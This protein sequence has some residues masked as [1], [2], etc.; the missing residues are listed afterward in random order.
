VEG[1]EE[2]RETK[3]RS[4]PL[5]QP[6]SLARIVKDALGCVLKEYD[7]VTLERGGIGWLYITGTNF[8]DLPKKNRL[9]TNFLTTGNGAS[10]R[11]RG[12]GGGGGGAGSV[13][14]VGGGVRAAGCGRGRGGGRGLITSFWK[15]AVPASAH[16]GPDAGKEK[17]LQDEELFGRVSAEGV[18]REWGEEVEVEH[19]QAAHVE[20]TSSDRVGIGV[21]G[22][23]GGGE[24]EGGED[25]GGEGGR[26]GWGKED[27]ERGGRRER[28]R[29]GEA[30]GW[31]GGERGAGEG[32]GQGGMTVRD[33]VCDE[34]C[35]LDM[36]AGANCTSH[37]SMPNAGG[38]GG[39]GGGEGGA[40]GLIGAAEHASSC[41][42]ADLE[43]Q[44]QAGE[45]DVEAAF[46]GATQC[47]P[48]NSGPRGFD[49]G[50]E[51][52]VGARS[53]SGGWRRGTRVPHERLSQQQVEQQHF[54]DTAQVSLELLS[55]LPG[56]RGCGVWCIHLRPRQVER[57]PARKRARTHTHTL[58][59]IQPKR[60]GKKEKRCTLTVDDSVSMCTCMCMHSRKEGRAGQGAN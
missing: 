35:A 58:W 39:G 16:Q 18:C 51:G 60:K 38:G 23:E 57:P 17:A 33:A 20:S 55:Q 6:Y 46:A 4:R 40:S 48:G 15:A 21:G 29:D 26:E 8:Q 24:R 59:T 7:T 44:G 25:E 43:R 45:Q 52:A 50:S 27:G 31:G 11:E 9:I 37:D 13:G 53:G 28:E 3:T 2:K 19:Q 1:G 41:P 32:G 34:M 42:R 14:G 49:A 22:G 36:R 56:V 30:E 12:G 5:Q 47:S 54:V 10:P